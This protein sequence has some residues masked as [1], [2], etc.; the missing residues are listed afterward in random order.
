MTPLDKI[1][2]P[3]FLFLWKKRRPRQKNVWFIVA[4]PFTGILLGVKSTNHSISSVELF[5][6]SCW[7]QWHQGREE[8]CQALA[9]LVHFYSNCFAWCF[10]TW[11][12]V[13]LFI[14]LR[15]KY[16]FPERLQDQSS[17]YLYILDLAIT[18]FLTI[19]KTLNALLP[20]SH[21]WTSPLS[22]CSHLL[23]FF[24]FCSAHFYMPILPKLWHH[25]SLPCFLGG[26]E[27]PPPSP[28]G[29][30]CQSME[31]LI[32]YLAGSLWLGVHEGEESFS[33]VSNT[34]SKV[35]TWEFLRNAYW[36]I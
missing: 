6:N 12:P 24:L 18:S 11:Q 27:T 35:C 1:S 22:E 34:E 21:F 14:V 23:P 9:S 16:E 30:L 31:P 15:V 3:P 28:H 33:C 7:G 8:S 20:L 26:L 10:P 5:R 25:F 2:S 36:R 13:N 32:T 17:A 19:C 4:S 29:I